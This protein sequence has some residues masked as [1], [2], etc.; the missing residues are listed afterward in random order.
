VTPYVGVDFPLDSLLG[1]LAEQATLRLFAGATIGDYRNSLRIDET[2]GNGNVERFTR[3]SVRVAP[4]VGGS[5]VLGRLFGS[6]GVDV[7]VKLTGEVTS[8]RVPGLSDISSLG[9]AYRSKAR[10]EARVGLMI[11]ITPR[12]ISPS[13]D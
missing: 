4:T 11:L 8:G 13:D 7:G 12:I 10:E 9:F 5:I 6:E 3:T 2:G 1:D